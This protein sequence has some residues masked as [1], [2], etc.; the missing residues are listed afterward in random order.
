MIRHILPTNFFVWR[1]RN[2][3]FITDNTKPLKYKSCLSFRT[4]QKKIVEF[5][6]STHT[7]Y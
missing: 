6:D 2:E 7:I 3:L 1:V 4:A 5:T